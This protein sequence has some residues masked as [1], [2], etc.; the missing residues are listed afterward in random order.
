MNVGTVT[1]TVSQGGTTIGTQVTSGTVTGGA[2][3]A[4]FVL[5]ANTAVAG[6]TITATYNAAGGFATSSDNTHTLT[7]TAAPTTTT[8]ASATSPFSTSNQNVILSATVTSGAGV[9][10][11]GT[12]TFTVS[13]GGTTIG[14]PVTS[15][16]VAAGAASATF[17]L[18][19]ATPTGV[20]QITAT[21]NAAGGFATSS[22]NT[23]TLTVGTSPTITTAADATATSST[24]NQNITLTATVVSSGGT[25]NVGTVT[26]TVSRGGTTI[27]SPA[28]GTVVNGS[29]SATFVLPAGTGAGSYTITASYNGAGGFASSSDNTHH[30]TV[31]APQLRIT[32]TSLPDGQQGVAYSASLT[33]N[34]GTPPVT[35]GVTGGA[36]PN[37]VTLNTSTGVISGTPTVA[38][39]FTVTIGL[40][41]SGTL[42]QTTSAS[43]S[44]TIVGPPVVTQASPST[45]HQ[46]DTSDNIT[47]TGQFT[48]FVQN[49][50]TVS[51]G[52]ADI[53]LNSVTV[54]SATSLTTNISIATNALIG[55][56]TVTVTTGSEVATGSNV[57]TVLQGLPTVTLSPNFGV[58]GSNPTITITGQFTH[59]TQGQTSASFGADI[60]AGAV[61]VNSPT[62]A[63]VQLGI[64]VAAN[65]G[66]RSITI[67]T[68]AESASGTFT[69]TAGVPAI[70][71]VTPNVGGQNSTI[72]VIVN[73]NFT[74]W[75]NG[76]TQ[77]SFGPDI[78]VGGGAVGGFGPVTVNSSGQ[79]TASLTISSTAALGPRDVTV[80][81]GS[82]Q[83]FAGAAFTVENCTTTAATVL[84]RNPA[85]SATGVPLNAELRWEFNS[86]INRASINST[87]V[88]LY[89]TV[90][91]QIVPS[92]VS[93][94]ASGKIV[95]LIPGQLMAV[96]RTNYGYLGYGAQVKDA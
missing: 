91:A 34:G 86:P 92:S 67:N 3:S 80:K 47:I 27:G 82:E 76:T 11:V 46:A 83:E 63:T 42:Q 79:L 66:A 73:A 78:S 9:V 18:P 50:S 45:G 44:F 72:S 88:Y 20:Y 5:P 1:F 32:T 94:D 55:A 89:D 12:V 62:Q 13:Q 95:T 58:Q 29:V 39:P 75:V 69:V 36:L 51:F 23:H 15:G 8:A 22:D 7:V 96:G 65:L 40:S 19:A 21:Y 26:F 68:G 31:N 38:G 81:T 25:V 64:S 2:A 35:W 90:T 70:I 93:V 48:H 37:G 28:S 74:S 43:F 14:S 56:R 53:T 57:F 16:T 6:Y 52:T 49:T 59:F 33:F 54:N 87:S 4:P 30:L 77:A 84:R 10:N 17:V 41:D 60:T 85:Y 61:T 24:V 71:S